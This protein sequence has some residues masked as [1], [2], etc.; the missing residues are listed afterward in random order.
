V[1]IGA[2]ARLAHESCAETAPGA[3]NAL[4]VTKL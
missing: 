4:S 2:E 3:L 1:R